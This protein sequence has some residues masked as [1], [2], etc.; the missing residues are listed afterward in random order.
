MLGSK[1]WERVGLEICFQAILLNAHA[2]QF[3]GLSNSLIE[4]VTR[5]KPSLQLDSFL[6]S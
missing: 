4:D 6:I 3:A 2:D 5:A 1:W